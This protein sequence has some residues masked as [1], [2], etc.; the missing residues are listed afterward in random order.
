MLHNGS[1]P[2]LSQQRSSTCSEVTPSMGQCLR[3]SQRW[4]SS[5]WALTS[6]VGDG[7]S[8]LAA[9]TYFCSWRHG[10]GLRNGP[11]CM[12]V[13]PHAHLWTVLVG[14][15]ILHVGMAP[16]VVRAVYLFRPIAI[17]CQPRSP[18][19]ALSVGLIRWST[20][21]VLRFCPRAVTEQDRCHTRCQIHNR[22]VRRMSHQRLEQIRF[23]S[24]LPSI[25][26]IRGRLGRH[27]LEFRCPAMVFPPRLVSH[28][29]CSQQG[30]G[31]PG[32]LSAWQS[33]RTPQHQ[34][35]HG[36]A[37]RCRLHRRSSSYIK[38]SPRRAAV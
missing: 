1:R 33:H 10:A 19:R 13:R 12:N 32:P 31:G 17:H 16:L 21:L 6:S 25:P 30:Q 22:Q 18:R 5:P 28:S 29:T 14:C 20:C 15:L 8:C 3:A 38:S 26:P 24:G 9:R 4:T 2:L 11:R 35:W 23:S 36:W 34:A 7:S 37:P 27:R